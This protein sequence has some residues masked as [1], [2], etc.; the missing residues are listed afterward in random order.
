VK[1][2]FL[3]RWQVLILTVVALLTL[4]ASIY[5]HGSF[6]DVWLT[7]DQQAMWHYQN[8]EFP[9]A[10]EMF[11]DP[12]WKGA[13]SYASG[14]Y[15]Q[16]GEIYAR[17]PTASGLF[18]RGNSL[19]KSRNYAGAIKSYERIPVKNPESGQMIRFMTILLR[20]AKRLSLKDKVL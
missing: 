14:L 2:L 9:E 8:L 7:R 1:R 15:E 4:S 6:L 12:M 3:F 18:N 16:A 11:V 13:A 20:E 17:I 19:I 5:R 10:A